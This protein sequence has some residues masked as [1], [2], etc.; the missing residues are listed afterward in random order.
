MRLVTISRSANIN[1]SR[2]R[3]QLA[4]EVRFAVAVED[5]EQAVG[6]AEDA[7]A[8]RI[9][10]AFGRHQAGR[11]EEVERGRRRLLGIELG[12]QPVEA[13]I[14]NLGDAGLS[15]LGLGGIGLGARQPLKDRA[16]A[17]PGETD[18]AD[19]HGENQK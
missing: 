9:V 4:G 10:A 3:V 6:L 2:K 7:E 18:D 17:R 8:A 19:F 11:V 12:R 5:D 14:G 13:R 1:S 15:H 16:L